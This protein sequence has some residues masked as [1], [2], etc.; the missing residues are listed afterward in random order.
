MFYC[1][2]IHKYVA[3]LFCDRK[4]RQSSK[5]SVGENKMMRSPVSYTKDEDTG[6][7]EVKGI[8]SQTHSLKTPFIIP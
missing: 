3:I 8:H 4:Q 6:Y 5:Y 7:D 2:D 1:M